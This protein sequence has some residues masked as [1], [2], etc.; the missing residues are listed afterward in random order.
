MS[1]PNPDDQEL[2]PTAPGPALAPPRISG[3]DPAPILLEP[4]RP[5]Q[6]YRSSGAADVFRRSPSPD[7]YRPEEWLASTTPRFGATTDGLS[8][9][10]DGRWLRD[11]VGAAPEAWLGPDHVDRYGD[12][13]GMLVKLLDAG[14][15]LPV[16]VHPSDRFARSHLG[17]RHGKTE[18][19]IVLG[20]GGAGGAGGAR[21]AGGAGGAG[22]W[23]GFRHDQD[24]DELAR[25]VASQD[26]AALLGALNHLEV[27]PGDAIVV[28]A[29][30]PHA[31]G[32]GVFCVELQEP[33]DLSLNLEWDGFAVP[34]GT[35]GQLGIGPD[36][37]LACVARAALSAADVDRLRTTVRPG[38]TASPTV[39]LL[40][41][42]AAPYFRASRL[43]PQPEVAVDASFAVL[44]VTRGAGR[45]D[46]ESGARIDLRRGDVILMPWAAG[47]SRI[48]GD[49]EIV[50][51]QPPRPAARSGRGAGS[52]D[53]PN[54]GARTDP[55]DR[56][57]HRAG[58]GAGD[59]FDPEEPR[60]A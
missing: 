33:T 28:P 57:N 49:V 4:N 32:P 52:D 50:R 2:D 51:C 37:V 44:V 45:I 34:D 9:L 14:E 10:P 12:D 39:D 24:A 3:A 5:R 23:L 17:S 55:G 11:A 30:T 27:T 1:F 19:W 36:E 58:T 60:H 47:P 25:W 6:F 22:V 20:A 26:T 7:A 29:G 56:P 8:H 35:E 46:T 38:V 13:V 21:G 43:R 40:G 48:G 59:P 18:A 42:D 16:H 41:P 31:I 53:R 54:D 15:R